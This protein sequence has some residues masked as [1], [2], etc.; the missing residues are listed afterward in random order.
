[1]R[2]CVWSVS[3]RLENQH[4]YQ[5]PQKPNLSSGPMNSQHLLSAHKFLIVQGKK[6]MIRVGHPRRARIWRCQNT[7]ARFAWYCTRC[8]QRPRS[9]SASRLS[10]KD[11]WSHSSYEC[12]PSQSPIH[13]ILSDLGPIVDATKSAEQKRLLEIELEAVGIRLNTRPP[14]VVFKQKQAG[15]ITVCQTCPIM[16]H[17]TD[18][19]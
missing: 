12:V 16:M 11:S 3:H 14:D 7:T 13:C 4:C 8:G 10:G 15:G 18:I 5:R 1:M 6:L 9:R 19:K 17:I 2:A